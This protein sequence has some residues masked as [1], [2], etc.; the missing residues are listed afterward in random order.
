MKHLINDRFTLGLVVLISMS[1]ACRLVSGGTPEVPQGLPEQPTEP[2]PAIPTEK[3]SSVDLPQ[4]AAT[5]EKAQPTK[6][7]LPTATEEPP[8]YFV[9]EFEADPS[10]DWG[11]YV[12][13]GD[14]NKLTTYF[15]DSM[16][17]YELDGPDIYAYYIYEYYT[18][19]DVRLDLEAENFGLNRNNVSLVCRQSDVEWY[20][21]SVESGGLWYLYAHDDGGFNL[22][23]SGGTK[24]LKMGKEVN[25]YGMTCQGD[26]ITM[27]INGTEIKSIKDTTYRFSEGAVGFNISSLDI[28]PVEIGVDWMEVSEP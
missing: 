15:E 12:I 5:L 19:E 18:Y 26:T 28:Y 14:E 11:L 3:P 9:E 2:P 13:S 24:L 23:G 17:F 4:P 20:E 1:L 6:P 8:Y 22:L 27:S 10:P 7:P 25:D 16:M 21:F